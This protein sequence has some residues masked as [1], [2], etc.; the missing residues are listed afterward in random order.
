MG[1]I[2]GIDFGT[3]N[4]TAAVLINGKPVIIPN[5]FGAE[6]TPSV[7]YIN[8]GTR[9]VLVG[10][11]AKRRAL[12]NPQETIFSV[13]RFLGVSYK[14]IEHLVQYLPYEVKKGKKDEVYIKIG[15]REYTAVELS[16]LIFENVKKNAEAFLNSEVN[17]A[18]VTVPAY[19]NHLQRKAIKS[20]AEMAGW[21]VKRIINEPTAAALAVKHFHIN[22]KAENP[23][24]I[25]HLGGGTIDV[26][27]LA[28]GAGVY[29][30]RY[31]SGETLMGG[32]DIDNCIQKWVKEEL[33]KLHENINFDDILFNS[34]IRW[35]CEKAKCILS[36][37][38]NYELDFPFITI[39]NC[40][41]SIQAK[42][43]LTSGCL[44]DLQ[45]KYLRDLLE[46]INTCVLQIKDDTYLFSHSIKSKNR[47]KL[48]NK[49][50][51]ENCIIILIG[52]QSK[53]QYI[54]KSVEEYFGNRTI[55]SIDPALIV[56]QGA[57]F[58][59]GVLSGEIWDT[60]LL[61]VTPLSLGI[62]TLGGVMTKLIESNTTIPTKKTETF[63]TAADNQSSVE[64]HVL[65]GER[66]MVKDNKTIGR[67]HLDGIPPAPRGV[68]Q[69]EVAFE[70]DANGILVVSAKDK[71]TGKSISVRY[72]F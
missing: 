32:D 8:K 40:E 64:I 12:L 1:T 52:Q 60:L 5:E 58:Q 37:A 56:A 42:V 25:V 28:V 27:V 62:E 3:T 63:T 45:G 43:E 29:E 4:T 13:K 48:K 59:G 49:E 57:A 51:F 6:I 38:D 9:E 44:D 70:I 71:A 68:A 11:A 61:D 50:I 23:T 46:I 36:T 31:T 39:N 15:R 54:R 67:F 10:E 26:S 35:E 18:V 41:K 69:I 55:R 33:S 34:Y 30:V 72:D 22:P 17:E 7:V 24:V 2:I 16:T 66:A 21:K 53:S 19:Y 14:D 65:Q 20:A 47:I